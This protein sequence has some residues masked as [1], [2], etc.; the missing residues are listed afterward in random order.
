MN[1]LNKITNRVKPS[2]KKRESFQV[3]HVKRFDESINQFWDRIKANYDFIV[4][5]RMEYLNWRYCDPRLSGFNIEFALNGNDMVLGYIVYKVN[6]YNEDYPIGYIVDLVT[7]N[8]RPDI[9]YELIETVVNYF[10]ENTVNV[11]NYQLIE[12][13]PQQNV[14]RRF[15]FLDSRI[16][17]HLFYNRYREFKGLDDL[18]QSDPSRIHISWGDHDALPVKMPTQR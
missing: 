11:V 5:R 6:R 3:K 17:I 7:L 15:G 18:S 12:G 4:E 8:N 2:F 10:Q 13:N 1:T 9:Q 16:N 14:F